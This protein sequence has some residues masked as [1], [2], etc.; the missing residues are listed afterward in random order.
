MRLIKICCLILLVIVGPL[1]LAQRP[2]RQLFPLQAYTLT[3]YL[4]VEY[5]EAF[6]MPDEFDGESYA[7]I[8]VN[9]RGNLVVFSRGST[10]FLEFDSAGR[11]VRAFGTDGLVRRAH[12][13][14]IEADG[15]IWV[16]DVADHVVLKLDG[17][18]NVLMTLGTRGQNGLW[19]EAAGQ[20]LFDQP[21]DVALDSRGNIYVAQGH[22]RG[23][24]RVLKFSP[25]G[26]FLAQWGSRGYG[27]GQYTAA[28]AI[29]IDGND[30]LYVA[31]RENMRI[32]RYDT[33]GEYLG[34]WNFDAMVCAIYL[35]DDGYLYI[36]TG[37]DGQL[38]KVAMDGQVLGAI[39]RPGTGNGEF[40]EAHALT[41]DRQ[42]NAYITDVI[43][44]RIQKF[45]YRPASPG[46]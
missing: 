29:E 13:L 20:H 24:P 40:G 26:R 7:A 23:E 1:T 9:G 3:E 42:N 16:T 22:G 38:A 5:R 32:H 35:H 39:G 8:A 19:D 10:P 17:N 30:N 44:R 41:L 2:N 34:E 33:G 6:A 11:F 45:A 14:Q 27:E 18:G 12:G 21:N 36:T 25:D 4:A 31:D 15:T 46:P 37:F 43:N 28:H